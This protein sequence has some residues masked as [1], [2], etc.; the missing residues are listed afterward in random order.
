MILDQTSKVVPSI[1]DA[2]LVY[3]WAGLRQ[4]NPDE[5]PLVGR[6]PAL[7]G[8]I[9]TTGHYRSGILLGL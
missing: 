7:D 1:N 4:H 5:L 6:H 3:S 8:L 9:L 2:T